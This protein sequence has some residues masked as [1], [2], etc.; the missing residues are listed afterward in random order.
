MES[1]DFSRYPSRKYQLGWL[2]L[3]LESYF[4]RTGK[5]SADVTDT[6]VE[7]IYVQVNKFA[8]VSNNDI[9]LH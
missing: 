1:T 7:T 3:F 4:Q 2:R 5:D 6:D 9:N 8:L